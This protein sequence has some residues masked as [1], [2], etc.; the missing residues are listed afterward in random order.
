MINPI[1]YLSAM[2]QGRQRMAGGNTA[3]FGKN[4]GHFKEPLRSGWTGN[5]IKRGGPPGPREQAKKRQ[6]EISKRGGA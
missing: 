5:P 2:L 3:G 1:F 6:H 4:R